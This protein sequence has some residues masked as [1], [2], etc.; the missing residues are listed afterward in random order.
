MKLRKFAVMLFVAL[1]SVALMASVADAQSK[2]SKKGKSSKKSSKGKSS[3][4]NMTTDELF[5]VGLDLGAN[6]FGYIP[7][8]SFEQDSGSGDTVDG[9]FSGTG[10]FGPAFGV[11][12][13]LFFNEWIVRAEM[14]YGYQSGVADINF[15]D[16][17]LED[18]EFDYSMNNFKIG[19][20]V[21]KVILKHRLV[22][23]YIAG[24]LDFHY[25]TFADKD[26]DES[27]SGSGFGIGGLA[28]VDVNFDKNFFAGGGARLDLI[29]T[30]NPLEL[31]KNGV[32]QTITMGYMPI[33]LFLT[34]GMRF[35]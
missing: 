28:G 1:L 9:S 10:G 16:E 27:A 5:H 23:P 14:G 6:V 22:R 34:G 24:V 20:G 13:H 12:A 17:D 25:L 18:Q 4:K 8:A 33:S 32:T 26:E 7:Y 19:V 31:K 35:R 11:H 29:Y 30:A 15:D 3:K 2:K 21:G